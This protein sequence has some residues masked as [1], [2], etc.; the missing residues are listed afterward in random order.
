M[1]SHSGARA[2]CLQ[3]Q[4]YTRPLRSARYSSGW[5]SLPWCAPLQNGCVLERPQ[6]HQ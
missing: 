5:K 3:A 1:P 2:E 4:K 6:L